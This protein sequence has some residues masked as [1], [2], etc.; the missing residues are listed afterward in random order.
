MN[1]LELYARSWGA[2]AVPFGPLSDHQW[3]SIPSQQR[4]LSLLNQTVALRGVM[5]LSGGNGMGKSTLVGRWARQLEPRLFTPVYLTQATLSSC[6]LLASLARGVGKRGSFRRERNLDELSSY[7]SEHE[8]QILLIVLDDAQNSTHSTLEELRLLLGLNLP[9][10]PTFALVLIGDEYLLGQLQ[11]RNHRALCS[12]LSAH[13]LLSPWTLEE[14]QT[15]LKT[16]LEAV[17]INRSRVFDPAAVD[18]LARA[19]AGVP[20]SVCLLARAAWL[21]A[22]R[23]EVKEI[24]AQTIQ[25]A[26]EQVPGLAGL[27]RN[28]P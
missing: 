18:L 23:A 4:A 3:V 1:E 14:I 11:L 24:N 25:Q 13:H 16:G 12:R 15:Y 20:R 9:S 5:L 10:Q 7:L 21:E 27:V 17:G 26:M 6:G 28:T 19:T 2:T 8:R 22:A